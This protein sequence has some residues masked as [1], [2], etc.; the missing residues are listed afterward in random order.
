[1][2]PTAGLNGFGRFGLHLLKYWLDRRQ[3]CAFEIVAINDPAISLE[4]AVSIACSDPYVGFEDC[5]FSVEGE[6]LLTITTPDGS[7]VSVEY[8]QAQGD[9]IPWLGTPDIFLECSGRHRSARGCSIYLRQRTRQVLVSATMIDADQV[10]IYGHNQRDWDPTAR[11]IS[12]GSCTVNAFIPI[13]SWIHEK[14]GVLDC[15]VNVIHNQPRHRMKD[16]LERRVCTLESFAP[17]FL[18][19]LTPDQF[20]VNYT[21]V[22]YSGASI[23]DLRFRV[24]RPP[25]FV[26][27]MADLKRSCHESSLEGLYAVEDCDSGPEPIVGASESAVIIA[28]TSR[29]RGSQVYLHSYFDNEN[30]A[31]RFF[32]LANFISER[33]AQLPF[34]SLECTGAGWQL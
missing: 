17:R 1:M 13:A 27:L 23:M 5:R 25:R 30:S 20:A 19:F 18:D 34:P 33:A 22:P 9:A 31:S 3:D 14:Y 2:K 12:Y 15:D 16:T 11:V 4:D 7:Q 21:I 29:V 6:V 28:Q 24:R 26:D 32:D 10:L 8:T